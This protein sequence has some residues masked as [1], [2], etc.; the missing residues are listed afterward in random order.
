M[1]WQQYISMLEFY[2]HL[3]LSGTKIANTGKIW[4]HTFYNHLNLSGTKMCYNIY[5]IKKGFY[6]HLNLSGT[7]IYRKVGDTLESFTIT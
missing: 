3:N 6:N 1:Y 7:K 5:I 2:N 4:H